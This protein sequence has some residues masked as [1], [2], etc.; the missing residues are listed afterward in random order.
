MAEGIKTQSMVL[1]TLFLCEKWD[2]IF[3]L[4]LMTLQ[5]VAFLFFFFFKSSFKGR[6]LFIFLTFKVSFAN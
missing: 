2:L 4:D 6:N 5:D 3:F 1:S